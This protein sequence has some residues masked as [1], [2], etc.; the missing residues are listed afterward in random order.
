LASIGSSPVSGPRKV[1]KYAFILIISAVLA[2]SAALWPS[3][4]TSYHDFGGKCLDCHIKEPAP[5]ET[6]RAFTKNV[7]MMCM[8]CHAAELELSHPVDVRPLGPTPAILPLDWKGDVT[9]ATCHP[10]HME[11]YGPFRLRTAASG[12]GFCSMCHNELENELHK[13]SLG[14]AHAAGSSSMKYVPMELGIVLDD[15]SLRCLSCHDALTGGDAVVENVFLNGPFF[16][17]TDQL[18]L[19]HPIGISY[20]E[21]RRKYRGAYRPIDKL[22]PEIKLFGGNVGCGTCHNPYSKGHSLLV[23]S[24]EG[25]ALCLGCHVK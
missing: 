1:R 25:S 13:L 3:Q 14:A 6:P 4:W 12:Q 23:M 17:N 2:G 10:V 7:T 22:P 16:H 18:G 9:C 24:N 20:I 5:G 15:L 8:G 19:S 21:A 11:G